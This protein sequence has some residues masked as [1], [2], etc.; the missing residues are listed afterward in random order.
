MGVVTGKEVAC[1]P[2]EKEKEEKKELKK[3]KEKTYKF[4]IEIEESIVV[5]ILGEM[6]PEKFAD[7]L[8]ALTDHKKFNDD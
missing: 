6:E 5:I 4:E 2:Y 1:N 8:K 7:C 3:N